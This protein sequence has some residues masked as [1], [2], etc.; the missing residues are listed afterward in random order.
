MTLGYGHDL[1][2]HAFGS[3]CGCLCKYVFCNS[4]EKLSE[5]EEKMMQFYSEPE[6]LVLEGEPL[7]G[8]YYAAQS[9]KDWLRAKVED[10]YDGVVGYM[11]IH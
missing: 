1:Q 9:G 7:V 10:I 11:N 5:L 4:Q 2:Q 8:H 3:F 6:Q